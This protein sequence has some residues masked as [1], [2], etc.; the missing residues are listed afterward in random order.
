MDEI[1]MEFIVFVSMIQNL[2]Q[3]EFMADNC[4]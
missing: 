1:L 2:L 3:Y 4:S